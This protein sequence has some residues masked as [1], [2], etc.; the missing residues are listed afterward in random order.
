MTTRDGITGKI[1]IK[2][3]SVSFSAEGEQEWLSQQLNTVIEA[4]TKSGSTL[5][6]IVDEPTPGNGEMAEENGHEKHSI[7][8]VTYLKEKKR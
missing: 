8:L 7:S 2:I 1:E 3:G 4:A 6:E 5:G